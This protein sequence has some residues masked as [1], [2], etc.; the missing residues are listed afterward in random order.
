[1]KRPS[2][3]RSNCSSGKKNTFDRFQAICSCEPWWWSVNRLL[4][5]GHWTK[6]RDSVIDW[7][8]GW[9]H[10]RVPFWHMLISR[11]PIDYAA[12][13]VW[14]K[15]RCRNSIQVAVLWRETEKRQKQK[16]KKVKI[17][18]GILKVHVES[19]EEVRINTR[20]EENENNGETLQKSKLIE[21]CQHLEIKHR[22]RTIILRYM[23]RSKKETTRKGSWTLLSG[24]MRQSEKTLPVLRLFNS[25]TSSWLDQDR[26][27]R[28]RWEQMCIPSHEKSICSYSFRSRRTV[29]CKIGNEEG[30]MNS[31]LK[32]TWNILF[33]CSTGAGVEGERRETGWRETEMQFILRFLVH[34]RGNVIWLQEHGR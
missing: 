1:M 7:L 21:R 30:D 29:R 33:N 27:R 18:T 23:D 15:R 25:L 11:G 24:N 8:T 13:T 16:T 32:S 9:T 3:G 14:Q 34:K 19:A 26:R 17:E 6:G 2:S 10:C 20:L 28:D 5:I 12:A 22:L 31:E 4:L